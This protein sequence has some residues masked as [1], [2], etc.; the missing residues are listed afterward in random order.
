M[1]VVSTCPLRVASMVWQPRAGAWALTVVCKATF[2]LQPGVSP[3]AELQ[4]APADDEGHWDGDEARSLRV[5]CDLVPF[6]A[7]AEVMLVGHAFAPGGQPARRLVARLAAGAVDKAIEVWCDRIFWQDGQLLEGQPFTRMPLRH[8]RAAGGPD[9]P[10]GMRFDA[11]PD[12]HGAVPVPNLQPPGLRVSRRGDTFAPVA[13]GPVAA[14]WPGRAGK[15]GRHAPGWSH[16]RWRERPLPADLDRAY[17]NA[18]PPDQQV[19]AIEPSLRL[20]LEHLHPEHPRL[21]TELPGVQPLARMTAG[22]RAGEEIALVAD[23]LWID[24]DRGL[25]TVVWRGRVPLGHAAEE[26]QVTVSMEGAASA[27]DV[28]VTLQV[29]QEGEPRGPALPFAP[30]EEM[31][32]PAATLLGGRPGAKPLPF[33]PAKS[34]WTGFQPG[35]AVVLAPV[36]AGTGTHFGVK[37][38][39]HA[40]LPTAWIA[41]PETPRPAPIAELERPPVDL[42]DEP[43]PPVPER[44]AE[45]PVAAGPT[46][47]R[48]RRR[49][50]WPRSPS[51]N[52]GR[53]R[54]RSPGGART[55]RRSSRRTGSTRRPGRRS[56]ITGSRRSAS[57][58]PG[59]R[60][61]CSRRTTG[62]TWRGSKKSAGRSRWRST[63]GSWSPRSAG[64][65]PRRSPR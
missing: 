52:A 42:D 45:P 33:G 30:E 16:A 65:S 2:Q 27:G 4:E 36:N 5:P 51:S 31:P 46:R 55:R 6:K 25:A 63:P 60:P 35:P 24:T 59:A 43:T 9:N 38:K 14:G 12:A 61:G 53:S 49:R 28:G 32:R 23:T 58:P 20:V 18:A 3:L 48:R 15:L 50:R 44:G 47:P 56:S 21:E 17:F 41:P 19:A 8:E 54:R 26:G 64:A 62:P 10:V 34:P 57:R 29:R 22:G 1:D 39:A 37:G 11:P 13:F 40:V 7:R